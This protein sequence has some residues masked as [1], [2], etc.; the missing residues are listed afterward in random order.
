MG[1]SHKSV[2][3]GRGYSNSRS[4]PIGRS[5]TAARGGA[6]GQSRPSAASERPTFW[7]GTA[8]PAIIDK[9]R[10]LA[11]PGFDGAANFDWQAGQARRAVL[12]AYG[13]GS[14][15]SDRRDDSNLGG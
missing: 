11:K 4:A 14:R 1:S 15:L 13:C 7:C 3:A 12:F 5:L 10:A 2:Q 6:A 9:G 8:L